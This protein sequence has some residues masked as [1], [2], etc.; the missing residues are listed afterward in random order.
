MSKLSITFDLWDT[1]LNDQPGYDT[2]R[3]ELRCTGMLNAL[4]SYG[5]KP[6]R[7]RLLEAYDR[8][9]AWL[10]TTWQTHKEISTL[11]QARRI[12]TEAVRSL[13]N[14]NELM[15]KLEDA[16]LK[17]VLEMPPRLSGEAVETLKGMRT[18]LSK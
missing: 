18:A 7:S 10:Q 13:P 16:Y 5:L 14:N 12:A 15:R 1:L 6:S 11:E 3:R 9:G 8:S 4:I 2:E 17:P